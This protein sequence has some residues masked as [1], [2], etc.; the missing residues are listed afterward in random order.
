MSRNRCREIMRFLR[1]DLRNKRSARLQTDK[2]AL[3][4][5]IWNR[6]VDNGI[7]CYKPG[8]NITI[9]EQLFPTKSRH[10]FTQHMLNK[11]DKLGI[12]FWFRIQMYPKCHSISGKRPVTYINPPKGLVIKL[13]SL[14]CNSSGVN[15]ET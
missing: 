13:S 5:D 14:L 12:K 10:R 4:S 15:A 7:S 3:I 1:F 2:F 11:P 8:E 6:F 9:D